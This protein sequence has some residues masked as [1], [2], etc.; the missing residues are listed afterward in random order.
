MKLDHG[1]ILF[2]AG[3]VVEN[4]YFPQSGIVSLVVS[5]STGE[6]VEAAMVGRDG[7]VGASSALDG[8]I[9]VT[10][11]IVELS[12]TALLCNADAFKAAVLK[13]PT[14]LAAIIRHEQAVLAQAQ[15]SAACIATHII[16]SRLARWLLRSRDLAE[17][18]LLPFTQEFLADML[19]ARRTSVSAVAH[20]LQRAGMIEYSRGKIKIV[21]VE[22]LH[23]T[24]CECYETVKAHYTDLMRKR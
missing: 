6:T 12:G 19:G 20:T 11:A 2:D 8:K 3:D 16:E 4:L 13:S 23:E 17:S 9:A 5:L 10:R 18:D 15:Q 7:V 21:N 24:A 22:A 1:K 14:L